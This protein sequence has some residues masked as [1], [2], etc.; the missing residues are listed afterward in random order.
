[1]LMRVTVR[2][3]LF[4]YSFFGM[5]TTRKT[6]AGLLVLS[7]VVLS[8]CNLFGG[9]GGTSSGGKPS[10]EDPKQVLRMVQEKLQNRDMKEGSVKGNVKVKADAGTQGSFDATF[11][12]DTKFNIGTKGQEKVWLDLALSGSGKGQGQSGEG[13]AKAQLFLTAANLYAKLIE[14]SVKSPEQ[15]QLEQQIAPFV[16]LYA[17]K[18]FKLPL[19]QN[20][21]EMEGQS[22]TLTPDQEAKIKD[23]VKKSDLFDITKDHGVEKLN[24]KDVR[25]LSVKLNAK[26]VGTFAK[27]VGE[28]TGSTVSDTEVKALEEALNKNVTLDGELWVG[29]SDKYVYKVKINM[30]TTD[31]ASQAKVTVTAEMEV[32]PE[33]PGN[34]EEPKDAQPL[35]L[36]GMMGAGAPGMM[37]GSMTQPGMMGDDKMMA[38]GMMDSGT[39]MPSSGTGDGMMMEGDQ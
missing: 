12:L 28:I 34:L 23:L 32:N 11:A 1:M 36:G 6:L 15:P 2:I 38:P 39:M 4:F 13:N 24:N 3:F 8:G 25:H 10:S 18:W 35:P 22:G 21:F 29:E 9:Q 31:P 37:D 27:Q 17:G 30:N 7:L 26:N 19:P 5:Y 16:Q 20:P 14:F 33:N